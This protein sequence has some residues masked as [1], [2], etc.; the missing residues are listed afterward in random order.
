[1]KDHQL[2]DTRQES[3][4]EIKRTKCV[5]GRPCTIPNTKTSPW[6]T[7]TVLH[8]FPQ[9]HPYGPFILLCFLDQNPPQ[10]LARW[11]GKISLPQQTV[12]RRRPSTINTQTLPPLQDPLIGSSC[13]ELP[14]ADTLELFLTMAPGIPL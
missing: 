2:P 6:L 5:V 4:S 1:M 11:R 3:Q 8:A 12:E 9:G 10:V 7:G 13:L 14:T